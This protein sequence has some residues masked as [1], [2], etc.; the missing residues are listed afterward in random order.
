MASRKIK[1][2]K[3]KNFIFGVFFFKNNKIHFFFP[4]KILKEI[5]FKKWKNFF[6]FKKNFFSIKISNK[7]EGV[8]VP[9][10]AFEIHKLG[11]KKYKRRKRRTK[12][13]HFR[14]K[15]LQT[16]VRRDEASKTKKVEP[17]LEDAL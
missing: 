9:W 12:K 1:T 4:T 10:N 5:K 7:R 17:R 2:L 15:I 11:Q 14:K 16:K 3:V 13:I 6:F 8:K